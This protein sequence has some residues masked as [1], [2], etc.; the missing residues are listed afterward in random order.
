MLYKMEDDSIIVFGFRLFP[1]MIHRGYCKPHHEVVVMLFTSRDDGSVYPPVCPMSSPPVHLH[2]QCTYTKRWYRVDSLYYTP[3][4]LQCISY[5]LPT[6][7][8]V[9]GSSR[10]VEP[11]V[12]RAGQKQSSGHRN[13]SSSAMAPS[14]SAVR[15]LFDGLLSS[16]SC[17][18][19]RPRDLPAAGDLAATMSLNLEH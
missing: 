19:F 15:L 3:N 16:L 1:G 13:P 11:V 12:F 7:P 17:L 6:S 8:S 9:S 18:R 4:A 2:F 14:P 5:P 10:Y